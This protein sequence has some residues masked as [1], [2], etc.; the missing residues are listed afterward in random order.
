M[1]KR[2]MHSSRSLLAQCAGV[3]I[4]GLF[5]GGLVTGAA[6]QE[7]FATPEA[8]VESLIT[9]AKQHEPGALTRIFG[10]GARDILL[11]GD[12]QEDRQRAEKFIA[13][14]DDAHELQAP[15]DTTRVLLLGSGHWPFPVPLVKQGDQW[16]FDLAAGKLEI[17]DRRIGENELSALEACRTFVEAQREYYRDRHDGEEVQQYAQ[18]FLS[19]PGKHDGLYWHAEKLTEMSPLGTRLTD[20]GL[21]TRRAG[22]NAPYKGYRFR[23]LTRQGAAAPGGAFDYMIN[24]RLLVGVAMLA[25]PAE[26]GS[27]GVMSFIC[28][29]QGR[30]YQKNLGPTTEKL[31]AE[32]SRYNPDKSWTLVDE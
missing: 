20:A 8:A 18:R 11:S 26:W 14:A 10:E 3:M 24:G 9:A 4:M 28:N 30:I 25:Y 19:S 5:A 23:I 32:I 22:D 27:T 31:A 6:A 17:Q 2:M 29:Q 1:G 16:V 21:D 15:N 13:E 7:H 12:D